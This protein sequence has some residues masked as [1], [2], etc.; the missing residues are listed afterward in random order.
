M[1]FIYTNKY[2]PLLLVFGLRGQNAS[3]IQAF[4]TSHW[5]IG[6][7]RVRLDREMV[8]QYDTNANRNDSIMPFHPIYYLSFIS[9]E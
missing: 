9:F 4:T 2:M 7:L 6:S 1:V 3:H 5:E 8:W